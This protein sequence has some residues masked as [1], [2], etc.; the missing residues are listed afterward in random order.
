MRLPGFVAEASL[1]GID[2]SRGRRAA[3]PGMSGKRPERSCRNKDLELAR[4]TCP[5]LFL[6]PVT[7]VV[8]MS[9]K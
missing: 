5:S 1:L 9:S 3:A 2:R 6:A 4:F 7:S 8:R